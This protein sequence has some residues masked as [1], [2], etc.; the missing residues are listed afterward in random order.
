MNEYGST[1]E[2]KYDN[3]L[4]FAPDPILK[5]EYNYQN[6]RQLSVLSEPQ[7]Y[8]DEYEHY[9]NISSTNRDSVNYPLHYNYRINFDSPLKNVKKIM[10]NKK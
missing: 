3:G 9:I 4:G 5:K 10:I 1:Y 7:V 2:L 6:G 8:Y